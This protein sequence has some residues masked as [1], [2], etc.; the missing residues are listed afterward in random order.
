VTKHQETIRFGVVDREIMLG[1]SGFDFLKGILDGSLPAPPFAETTD[2]WLAEVH[3]GRVVFEGTPSARFFNPIGSVHGGW[4]SMLI[5]STLACAVQTRLKPGQFCTTVDM[6]TTFVR[7]V[8]PQ[9]GKLRCEATIIHSGGRIATAQGTVTDHKGVIYAHGSE[10]CMV[11]S[12]DK[13]AKG[14]KA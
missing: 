13:P 5:D 14:E 1:L 3:D 11:M 9:T 7:P 6:T 12:G 10:T 4:I 2:I 8:Y